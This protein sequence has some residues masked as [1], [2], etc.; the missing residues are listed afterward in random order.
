MSIKILDCTIRDGGHLCKWEF[1]H[2]IVRETYNAAIRSG[3]EYF[4][5]GYR[6]IDPEHNLNGEFYSSSDEL[7]KNILEP[8]DKCKITVM[9][10][11]DKGKSDYFVKCNENDTP[12][13]A[14][15][16]ATYPHEYEKALRLIEELNDKGYEVFLNL[17]ACSKINKEQYE[18]LKN[19]NK[20]DIITSVSFA[21]SF[22]AFLPEDIC[23][24]YKKLK[25]IGFKHIGFHAHNNLQLA[26]AN[27]LKAIEIGCEYIDASAYGMGRGAGNLPI[28]VLISY[29]GKSEKYNVKPYL[30]IIDR[31]YLNKMESIRWGYSLNSLMGGIKNIHPYYVDEVMNKEIYAIDE[32]WNVIDEIKDQCPISF[33]KGKID[34]ILGKK[35]INL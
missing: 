11:A 13:R 5:V 29:L 10:D 21:D 26:F 25:S 6:N 16:V 7:L 34:D 30:N 15:R 12:V 8:S 19:W 23:K 32:A 35:F 22:G 4:E 28:E 9:V 27:A 31:Y 18:I 24:Y 1:E 14:V 2:D 17:M 3:V 20:K 33:S